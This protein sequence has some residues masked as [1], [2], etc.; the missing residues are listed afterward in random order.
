VEGQAAGVFKL[1]PDETIREILR[2]P[3]KGPVLSSVELFI[4]VQ[5]AK[6]LSETL[7]KEWRETVTKILREGKIKIR[8][9]EVGTWIH[10]LIKDDFL[11]FAKLNF[12]QFHPSAEISIRNLGKQLGLLPAC[13]KRLEM[14]VIEYIKQNTKIIKTLGAKNEKELIDI[15]SQKFGYKK[16]RNYGILFP[17]VCLLI[18]RRQLCSV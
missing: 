11:D 5:R 8:R 14:N 10:S 6:K 15:L 16:R 18:I 17:M 3:K 12:P 9:G 13:L 2:L 4:E 7:L 1:Q